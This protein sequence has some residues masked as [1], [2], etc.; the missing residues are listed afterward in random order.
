[1]AK[2]QHL[3][4]CPYCGV[5]CRIYVKTTDGRPTGI[6][7]VDDIPGIPNPGGKLCPKGNAVL[8]YVESKDRLKYP[9]KKVAP[10]KFKRISWEEAITESA[11][12]LSEIRGKYGPDSI[13][14]F[15]SGKTYNEP[16][17]LIQKLARISGTNNIDHCA[18]LYHSSTITGLTDVYGK[19]AMTNSFEDVAKAKAVI[20]WGHNMAETSPVMYDYV[21]KAK[22][23]GATVI[24]VDP[25]KTR[26]AWLA[27]MHLQLYSGTDI[28]LANAMIN[29]IITEGLYDKEF[30]EKRT[31]HFEDLSATVKKYTPEYAEKITGVKAELIERAATIFATA[32]TGVITW[33]TGITQHTCG[34]DNVRVMA[35][36]S[37]I[38]G[39]EGKEGCG[40]AASCDQNN[41]QGACDM[42]ALPNVFTGY[43]KVIDPKARKKFEDLWK[44]KNLP[45]KPGYTVMEAV[46]AA[47]EGKVKAC[48]VMGENPVV[49]GANA[50]HVMK[51][52]QKLD[53][54][55]VQDLYITETAQYA[56][57]ILPATPV[58][59]S[60]GS[61][62]NTE[63]RVQWSFQALE[64]TGESKPDWWI[65]TQIARK[66]GFAWQFPYRKVE[67]VTDE[68]TNVTPIYGDVTSRRLKDTLPGIFWPCPSV[69]HPGTRI[70]YVDGFDKPDGK[71]QLACCEY[72]PPAEEP[73]KEYPYILTT[74]KYVGLSNTN[75]MTGR[76]PS[77]IKRWPEPL[78]EIHP[79][80]AEKIG[81]KDGEM[82]KIVTRRGEYKC[83]AHVTELIKPGE[84]AVAWHWGANV[85]TNDALD[86]VSKIPETKVCACKIVPLGTSKGKFDTIPVTAEI[87]GGK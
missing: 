40:V 84:V 52:L 72:R 64:P 78:L 67:E 71:A 21:M 75:T 83:R 33:A 5:G 1:M 70:L 53:F 69:D 13:M 43:Q 61:I 8:E 22:D 26:S 76:S 19:G 58:I 48:Y 32:G 63:R 2:E 81:M 46:H 38:C 34:Y 85:V 16:N 73:D 51:A 25:R 24:V 6:E 59:E 30:V 42:G 41:V 80:D 17:Y 56:D 87:E 47:L 86:P 7:Y 11:Q 31:A 65:V 68:I 14:Y 36:L 20:I 54:L 39:Y 50:H 37:A 55:I 35:D 62:T 28:A 49:S 45:E 66:M 57:I 23:N 18:R 4:V 27:D 79:S 82:A 9:L 74:I 15:G 3:I 12:R 10:G 77:L 29:V 44:V 60:C